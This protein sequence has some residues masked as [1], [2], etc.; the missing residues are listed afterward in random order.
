MSHFLVRT[1]A[2]AVVLTLPTLATAA[3]QS[4]WL[5]IP[6]Q[7]AIGISQTEQSATDAYIGSNRLPLSAITS[8]A[9][10]KFNQST[11]QLRLSYGLGDAVSLDAQVGR[12]RVRAGAADS[13][14][15]RADSTLGINWRVLDEFEQPAWPTVTLRA[16]AIL[17]GSYRGDR[18]A[19]LGNAADGYELALSLGKQITPSFALWAG[20]GVEDRNQGVPNNTVAEI[21]A[22]LRLASTWS[23]GL[24]VSESRYGG[25]LDIGGPGFSPA[26]FQQIKAERT[27]VKA[28]LGWAPAGNQGVSLGLAKVTGGRNTTKDDSIVSLAYTFA[29]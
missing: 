24:G 25:N 2:L 6:G 14:S 9:A 19:A 20:L 15:G 12:A 29:F 28:S 17:K 5:P 1:A 22:R 27:L 3:G 18:L 7:F 11:T 8:G 21:H 16:A 4:P 13:D 26:R 10:S 23:V